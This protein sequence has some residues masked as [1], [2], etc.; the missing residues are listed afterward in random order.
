MI[1]R[2]KDTIIIPILSK[3][4][5]GFQGVLQSNIS[6]NKR[7]IDLNRIDFGWINYGDSLIWH[8]NSFNYVIDLEDGSCMNSNYIQSGGEWTK[9]NK[10]ILRDKVIFDGNNR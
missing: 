4:H 9:D 7:Y 1:I 6:P 2:G 8:E 10:Y 3:D 5:C